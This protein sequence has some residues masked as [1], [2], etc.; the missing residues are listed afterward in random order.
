MKKKFIK[1]TNWKKYFVEFLMLFLA[2]FL[3]F[4]A[5]SLR[6]K[7]TE[8]TIEKTYI[9]SLIQDIET[10][11]NQIQQVI[12]NNKIR[13]SYID[14]LSRI[15]YN[16]K[17]DESEN[18]KIYRYLPIILMRP[19]F[20]NP[21]ELTMTQLKNSGGMRLI[22]NKNATREIWKYDL[23]EKKLKNQQQYYE[24]YH[25]KSID[26]VTKIFDL[27]E[28][29]NKDTLIY[30]KGR[31]QILKKDKNSLTEFANTVKMYG[32]IVE[33]YN[34]LLEETE[35]QADSLVIKVKYEYKIQ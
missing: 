30:N 25:N 23:Q 22:S 1:I 9:K 24:K 10:D 8:K 12:S 5:D 15:C 13:K 33:Y 7:S 35:K 29:Y 26:L 27:K 28:V 6:D 14:S 18:K 17:F 21:N 32:G 4:F 11:K 2:V 31:F 19:D 3:G 20:Y 34:R 16:Y